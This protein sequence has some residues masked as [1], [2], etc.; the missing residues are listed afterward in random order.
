MVVLLND[1][2]K[3]YENIFSR[4]RINTDT[5]YLRMKTHIPQLLR[6]NG[7]DVQVIEGEYT[8]PEAVNSGCIFKLR[9]Y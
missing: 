3:R 8:I 9:W 4:P 6:D 5:V 1:N 2:C 7:F